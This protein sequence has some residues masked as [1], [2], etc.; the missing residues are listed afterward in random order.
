[1]AKKQVQ[2]RT[3][4]RLSRRER[5][6]MGLTFGAIRKETQRLIESGDVD[7]ASNAEIA[8]MVLD[9][10]VQQNPKCY[11]DPSLDLEGILAFIETLMPIILMII[12]LMA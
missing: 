6:D 7:G 12:Q 10:L 11:S 9:S 4:D 3:I 1:M 5:R 2:K 8:A